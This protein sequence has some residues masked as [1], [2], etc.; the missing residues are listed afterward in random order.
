M[1]QH[2]QQTE[3]ERHDHDKAETD[4][5]HP[6]IPEYV[7]NTDGPAS[8]FMSGAGQDD[9]A[10]QDQPDDARHCVAN[11]PGFGP[12]SKCNAYYGSKQCNGQQNNREDRCLC[13]LMYWLSRN[14]ISS[15]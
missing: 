13:F 6:V 1:L 7:V 3:N 12:K 11:P 9:H 15:Y 4:A 10:H 2:G 14:E 5:G 8:S